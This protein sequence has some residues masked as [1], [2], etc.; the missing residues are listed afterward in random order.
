MPTC[1]LHA[2]EGKLRSFHARAAE[3]HPSNCTNAISLHISLFCCEFCTKE[4]AGPFTRLSLSNTEQTEQLLALPFGVHAPSSTI[5][6]HVVLM[7]HVAAAILQTDISKVVIAQ[8]MER[9]AKYPNLSYVVSDCRDMPEFLD[10]QFGHVIDKGE[11]QQ[12]PVPFLVTALHLQR[13]WRCKRCRLCPAA[14]AALRQ[15]LWGCMPTA[16][17][18][19]TNCSSKGQHYRA[20]S[21]MACGSSIAADVQSGWCMPSRAVWQYLQEASEFEDAQHAVAVASGASRHSSTVYRRC[22]VGAV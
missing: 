1:L 3:E 15:Q 13:T 19:H 2:S 16:T 14:A 20:S 10:C 6:T 9:H 11:Q 7:L 4:P 22:C 17:P 12:Q 21:C 5:V 18:N 8:L